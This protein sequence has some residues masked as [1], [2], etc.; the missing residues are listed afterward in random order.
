[1]KPQ[2]FTERD[3]QDALRHT[4]YS[5]ERYFS[6]LLGG[7]YHNIPGDPPPVPMLALTDPDD[8]HASN[9]RKR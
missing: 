6:G 7:H 5:R 1:M 9:P 2:D 8:W 4:A 3:R